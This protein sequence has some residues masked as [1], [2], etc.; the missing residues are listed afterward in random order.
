MPPSTTDDL[1]DFLADALSYWRVDLSW[2]SLSVWQ[3]ACEPFTLEQVRKAFTAH[4]TDPQRGMFPP[5]VADIV[6]ALQGTHG[7]RSL[8][9][10]GKTLE[11]M[12]RVGAWRDVVFDDPVIHAVVQDLGGWVKLCRMPSKDIGY[13][14]HRFCQTYQAYASV[15]H[16]DYPAVLAGDCSPGGE[17]HRYGLPEPEVVHIGKRAQAALVLAGGSASKAPSL[18][19]LAHLTPTPERPSSQPRDPKENLD[20]DEPAFPRRAG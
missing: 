1:S 10:W 11:A 3:Q 13:V 2:F 17:Y 20:A 16:L 15:G 9:A 6:R 8:I 19:A 7:D 18:F 12:S 5:K 14:Q 4:A